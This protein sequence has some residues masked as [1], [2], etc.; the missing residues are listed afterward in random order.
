MFRAPLFLVSFRPFFT[1]AFAAAVVLPLC[2]A[3]IFSGRLRLPGGALPPVTWHVHEMLFGFGWAVLGGFLL[4]ASKNWVKIRGLHGKPLAVAVLLWLVERA[5]VLFAGALP[6]VVRWPLLNAFLLFVAG[7]VVFSLVRYREQDS[8][9]D[10]AFFVVALPLF[11]VAKNL[12]FSAETFAA[13]WALALGLFRV[14][15]VVMFERTFPPFMKAAAKVEL[16]L[17][18]PLDFSIKALTLAAAFQAWLPPVVASGLLFA[19][20]AALGV[21]FVTWRPLLGLQRFPVAVMYVGYLGLVAHLVLEG[22]RL[23]GVFLGLGAIA[24]HTFAFLC[25]GVVVAA[26]MI[27]ISQG[28]TAR[29]LVF[30]PSDRLGFAVLGAGAFFRLVAPQ[31][32]AAHY[33]T[34]VTLAAVCWASCYALL[35]ARLVPFLWRPRLDGKEH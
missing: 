11:L 7:Y 33:L 18:R 2:W 16:P 25:L 3:L 12:I 31:L 30:T 15:F 6:A 35:G 22:L 5:A 10:N 28:H 32:W 21:R 23:Q 34:W 4:T 27:R 20:A 1:L 13:G 17:R 14:A 19:A 9:K 29:P 26:M 24:T 8:F